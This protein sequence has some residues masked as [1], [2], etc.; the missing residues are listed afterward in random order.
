MNLVQILLIA[1]LVG[2]VIVR[3]FTG[4]PLQGR[5]FVLPLVI[6]VYGGYQLRDVRLGVPEI[7]FLAVEVLL[8][9]GLGALRGMT[10]Q[11]YTR[12]GHLWQRYRWTTLAVWIVSIAVRLGLAAGAH[13][14]G[15]HLPTAS[16]MVMLGASLLAE[17]AIVGQRALRTGVPFAPSQRGDRRRVRA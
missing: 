13:V 14:A 2:Y 16:L 17:T 4:Q 1:A 5:S 11:I 6:T 12:A 7:T 9:L 3:R 15:L 10:I 8:A